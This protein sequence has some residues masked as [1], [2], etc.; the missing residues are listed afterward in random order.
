MLAFKDA[1]VYFGGPQELNS[2]GRL[3]GWEFF[4]FLILN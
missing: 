2:P 4:F 3:G 1:A